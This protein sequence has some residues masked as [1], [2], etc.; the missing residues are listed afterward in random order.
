MNM[1]R[2]C[3]H[4]PQ[5]ADKA[6]VSTKKSNAPWY[7]TP[8][9][10]SATAHL[11]AARTAYRNITGIHTLPPEFDP[12]T[13]KAKSNKKKK[14]PSPGMHS[15]VLTS[16]NPK[17]SINDPKKQTKSS[18]AAM[19]KAL[20]TS[21]HAK[22]R[23]T[24]NIQTKL[25]LIIRRI[26]A[27]EADLGASRAADYTNNL[28]N[29][30]ALIPHGVPDHIRATFL[31]IVYNA[32]PFKRRVRFWSHSA[33]HTCSYCGNGHEDM[34]HVFFTCPVVNKAKAMLKDVVP[35]LDTLSCPASFL[36]ED[37][38]FY[39][40]LPGVQGPEQDLYFYGVLG[41]IVFFYVAVWKAMRLL[42]G[43]LSAPDHDHN[44]RAITKTFWNLCTGTKK[45]QAA[46]PAYGQKISPKLDFPAPAPKDKTA[47]AKIK[48]KTDANKHTNTKTATTNS[49]T[50]TQT[51][52][53]TKAI[54]VPPKPTESFRNTKQFTRTQ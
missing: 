29:N 6:P 33:D 17:A 31:K 24:N 36:M 16:N 35:F 45:T 25:Q 19:Y 2:A 34:W 40:G 4:Y 1:D 10:C 8:H 54:Y 12:K 52:A 9:S 11:V 27:S 14:K 37:A 50:N 13:P 22:R 41:P 23:Y 18:S 26:F 39:Y 32:L 53:K 46:F 44:A 28:I 5:D 3:K 20:R 47:K 15:A 7:D 48:E 49:K 38:S 51:E 42:P 21:A 30:Y 43:G